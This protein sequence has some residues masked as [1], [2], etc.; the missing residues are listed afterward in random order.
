[1]LGTGAAAAADAVH[2]ASLRELPEQR[3][4]SRRLLIVTAERVG[5]AGVRVAED[6]HRG[7]TGEVRQVGPHLLGAEGAVDADGQRRGVLDRDPERLD[8]LPGEVA[9]APVDDRNRDH[10]RQ[11]GRHRAGGGDRRLAVEGVKD[12]FHQQVVDAAVAEPAGGLRITVVELVV[13]DRPIGRIVNPGRDRERDVGRSEGAGDETIG[14]ARG[15]L[16][17]DLG[18]GAVHLV[19]EGL[20]TE[21]RL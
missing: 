3:A 18:A 15:R 13:G 5:Q 20:E 8:G 11:L 17:S 10:Q 14:V 21:V 12:G 9:A 2:K 6:R 19:D 1:M 7:G 4:G 16:P